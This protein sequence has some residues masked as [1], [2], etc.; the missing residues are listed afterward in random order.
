M[1]Q[2]SFVLILLFIL[3]TL[4][5][6]AQTP[7]KKICLAQKVQGEIL[8][9]DGKLDEAGWKLAY[10]DNGF[11]QYRPYDGRDAMQ[12]TIFAILYDNNNLYVGMKMLDTSPDS[13]V[14]RLTRRDNVDGDV[15]GV[16]I[17]SYSDNRTAFAFAVTAAG[18][19]YDF[20]VSNDGNNEDATWNPVW[21]AAA[22]KDSLGWYAEMRIPLTQLRFGEKQEQDWGFQAVR[23]LFRK[24]ETDLWQPISPKQAGFVSFFGRLKGITGI[25]PHKIADLMPYVVARTEQFEKEP[26]N[27]FLS[28]GHKNNLSAGL[29]AKIGLTNYLTMDLTVNPDFGQVEADPSEVNLSTYETFFQE[30]RPFF[31]EGNNILNFGLNFG[32]GDLSDE[33]LFYSR[34]IGR[35]PHYSPDL[36]SGSYADIPEVTR[37]LGAAKIT[38]KTRD[39]WSI[40]VLESMTAKENAEVKGNNINEK[41][42]V[43]PFTNFAVGRL[44]KDFNEG[45]TYLGGMVTAVNRNLREEQFYFLHKSA[46]SGGLDFVHKWDNKNW[47]FETSF[48]G[49]RVAG[50]TEAITR[51]QEAWTHLFQRPD[52]N[53]LNYD[54]TRTSL[55]GYG[56]KIVLGEYG[57][58]WKFM[59]A[60]ALKSPGLELNDVGYMRESNN[61]LGCFWVGYHKQEPFSIFNNM[62]LNSDVWTNLNFGGDITSHGVEF[63]MSTTFKNYWNFNFN[64]NVNGQAISANALRGGPSLTVPGNYNV[65]AE[66]GSNEQKKLTVE[67]GGYTNR[68]F[69]RSYSQSQGI[70]L[71]I[72]YRPLK[73]LKFSLAPE[74]NFSRSELQY[75]T[76]EEISGKNRYIFGTIKR[77]TLSASLRISFN[78]TPELSLQ[79]WGQPFIAS[80]KYSHFKRI[81]NNMAD[82]Y[83]DRFKEY[84]PDEITYN[85]SS[86]TYMVTENG[87]GG[88]TFDQPDFNIKEFL[89]NMVL[90]W[91]YQPG[92]TLYIVWSQNRDSSV[93]DGSFEFGRD[94]GRLFDAR[95]GNIF[96]VKLSYRL[97]R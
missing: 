56:G 36:E 54:T 49:S 53:Y 59:G 8:K 75:I 55:S 24:D 41:V 88:I 15:A 81:T 13:I 2:A 18:V 9:I 12:Q 51:T 7:E 23:Y 64:S 73:M 42:A 44:Q 33:G 71:E 34:R 79:Y 86:E 91:E 47:Q 78:L 95:A 70:D 63:S 66:I 38:G 4:S 30:Q 85:S 3:F 14:Q 16:E 31:I 72:G 35:Q 82:D 37:I 61:I 5:I 25:K 21:W 1:K 65:W 32:D 17:D 62:Y 97:G 10:W 6:R 11:T 58:N 29:D 84:F 80:G 27:P 76:Q 19:K 68:G 60:V 43:E 77:N 74:Y 94:F 50:S 28:S 48:Y 52:A 83:T 40:G 20:L 87:F 46:Y 26:D 96:L 93:S 22:S 69:I 45:N 89:S 92:S 57:G 39:G 90:R 67:L